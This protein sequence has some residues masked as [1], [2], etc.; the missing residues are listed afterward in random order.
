[1]PKA[2]VR[3]L[4]ARGG[5]LLSATHV[6]LYR[7][8]KGTIG[9]RFG[10]RTLL[11][12]TTTGRKSGRQ[13]TRPLQYFMDGE[14]YVVAASNW[15]RAHPPAWYVNLPDRPSA[16][17]QVGGRMVQVTA[18]QASPEEK[19]RLWPMLVARDATF[20]RYQRR[21]TRDIPLMLLRRR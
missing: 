14:S 18:E 8:T 4:R 17:I 13:R 21:T 6:V 1:M 7:V 11:L 15:G 2:M 10:R 5:K 3:Q 12:L 9:A 16:A 19:R 20:A